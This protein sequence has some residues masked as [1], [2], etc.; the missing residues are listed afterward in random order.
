MS[1]W[2]I[3]LLWV[4]PTFSHLLLTFLYNK[5]STTIRPL[6][7]F[8]LNLAV[9]LLIWLS[10]SI[11]MTIVR[12][13]RACVCVGCIVLSNG[14]NW[15]KMDLVD[16]KKVRCWNIAHIHEKKWWFVLQGH[17]DISS[18]MNFLLSSYMLQSFP[19]VRARDWSFIPECALCLDVESFASV[20]F[21]VNS[22]S[23]TKGLISGV[24]TSLGHSWASQDE[25]QQENNIII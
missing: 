7:R 8:E 18:H 12:V 17:M 10:I 15:N 9:S 3:I 5:P 11:V 4:A 20:Y 16:P 22:E 19:L 14:V 1:G 24:P 21:W 25:W 2:W 23:L 6:P 13:A